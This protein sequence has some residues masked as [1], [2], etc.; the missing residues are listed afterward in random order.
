MSRTIHLQ[1]ATRIEGSADLRIEAEGDRILSAGLMVQDFRGFERF[2]RGRR[3]ET[4][5][6]LVSRIC[7]LCSAS[8]Q[9]ASVKAV[10][11]ALGIEVPRTVRVLR[12]VAYLGEWIS[13]HA[14]SYF[15]LSMPDFVGASGGV[16][17]LMRTH[18]DVTQDALALRQAGQRIVEIIGGRAV[19]PVSIEIGGFSAPVTREQVDE[20]KRLVADVK[21]RS[22]GLIGRVNMA[23]IDEP[24]ITFPEGH[25]VNLVAYD[26]RPSRDVFRAF[27]LWGRTTAEFGR[28][29]FEE[30][31]AEMRADWSFAKF[32]YLVEYGFPAGIML[33][34]PLSRSLQEGGILDDAELAE[35]D[36]TTWVRGHASASI[37]SYDACRLLELAWAA[38]RAERLLD[39]LDITEYHAGRDLAG[40]GQGIGVIEAPRGILVHSYL[41][42][43]GRLERMRLLVATQFNNAF[44]N[45]LL[46]DLAE[47]HLE[48]G[49][50][51]DEGERLVGRCVRLFDPCLSCATH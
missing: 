48:D 7:G 6:H 10:E 17:E 12:E 43:E 11:D 24:D 45:L 15:F 33:V 28:H 26:G 30:K 42:E 41:V 35:F 22:A 50:L 3:V 36:L 49:H 8:H 4:V 39:G 46:K 5:S 38:G 21:Q 47:A 25:P 20:L 31:V 1:K 13:S 44:V 51:T 29:E 23:H 18:P 37:E 2:I 16:F 32:P 34:G 9:V 14:L 27:D 40:S 19:H